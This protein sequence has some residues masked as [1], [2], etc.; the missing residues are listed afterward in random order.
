MIDSAKMNDYDQQK[1][2]NL[3][4]TVLLEL[5]RAAMTGW[6]GDARAEIAV[7]LEALKHH[8]GLHKMEYQAIK[9]ALNAL[10]SLRALEQEEARLVAED[11]K[12]LLQDAARN[13]ESIAPKFQDPGSQQTS[14]EG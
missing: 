1:W 8:P 6:I 10:S 13:L 2:F 12:R 7:R 9:D 4:R 5:K 14:D 3:Y 11:K